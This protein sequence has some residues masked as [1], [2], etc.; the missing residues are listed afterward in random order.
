MGASDGTPRGEIDR[1]QQVRD[2]RTAIT[3]AQTQPWADPDRTGICGSSY[4]GAHVLVVAA[5]DKRV[6]GVVSQ[7]PL[8]SGLANARRLTARPATPVPRRR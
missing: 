5:P 8:V 4:G 7:V 2:Y 1:W 6:R 3:W